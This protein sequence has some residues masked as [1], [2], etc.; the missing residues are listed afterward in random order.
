MRTQLPLLLMTAICA[1]GPAEA[2]WTAAGSGMDFYV[3]T[4]AVYNDE[5]YAG[6][7]FEHADGNECLGIGHRHIQQCW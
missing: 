6:G 1:S 7:N 3:H 5:L 4:S 2:Q